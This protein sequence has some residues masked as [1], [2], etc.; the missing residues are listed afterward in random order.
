M[1][2][3]LDAGRR[4]RVAQQGF[5]MIPTDRG[6]SALL[7]A[8]ATGEA[9]LAIMPVDWGRV[10]G[11]QA[12]GTYPPLLR[13][14]APLVRRE[15]RRAQTAAPVVRLADQLNQ[16][17]ASEWRDVVVAFVRQQLAKVLGLQSGDAIGEHTPLTDV[18]LD[19][20]M[21]IELRNGL[22]AAVAKTLP[23]SLVY[24]H[25][26]VDAL[27]GYLLALVTPAAPDAAAAVSYE[28]VRPPVAEA[29][30][31]SIDDLSQEQLAALLADRLAT[32]GT[33]LS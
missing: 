13:D 30:P 20:L 22:G 23:A 5:G 17:P 19:S 15:T 9:Q 14:L 8:M 33:E 12:E 18:G 4:D 29:G 26:T 7:R 16:T 3:R 28:P 1:A 21:A 6:L 31:P 2:A 10:L 32:L 25:P 11:G 24:D 27:A